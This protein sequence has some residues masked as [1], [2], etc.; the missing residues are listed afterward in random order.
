MGNVKE[1]NIE[2]RKNI[3]LQDEILL[4][5]EMRHVHPFVAGV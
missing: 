4:S 2:R 1:K 5:A 3:Y